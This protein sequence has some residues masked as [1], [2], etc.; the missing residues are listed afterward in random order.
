MSNA[1]VGSGPAPG[2]PTAE[3]SRELGPLQI[4]LSSLLEASMAA[5]WAGV[6][7]GWTLCE[8]ASVG[9]VYY[10]STVDPTVTSKAKVVI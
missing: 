8:G 2:Q 4:L 7:E 1:Q 5:P 3:W 6:P 9:D 10:R